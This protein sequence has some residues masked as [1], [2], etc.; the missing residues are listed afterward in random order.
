MKKRAFSLLVTAVLLLAAV[1]FAQEE[2]ASTRVFDTAGLFSADEA[3]TL[4][5][6]IVDF[7]E[8]TGYDFAI[9]V[10]NEDLGTADY[11]QLCDDFFVN[12]A[13]G[14]GMNQTA[15]LCYLD[16]Y[17]DGYYYVSA[18]GD[19]KNLMVTEDIQ[20][21]ANT[22]MEYFVKGDISGGFLWTINMLT[23]ALTN[24]GSMNETIRVYDYAEMLTED[25]VATLESAIADF[26]ALS[27]KDFLYLSTYENLQGNENGDYMSG[28]YQSHGFGDGDNRSGVMIY[29]DLYNNSYYVQ[30][31]GD[32][33]SF[34]SQEALNQIMSDS[35]APMGEGKV[36]D[37]VLQVIGAYS[38]YFQ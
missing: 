23:E 4:S 35:N 30:N 21:L 8:N 25:E 24:I 18:Y 31:F 19:L 10:T 37:A 26:R 5:A 12:H 9:Y 14:L 29:L 22:G 7:Q 20:Y 1:S 27:G 33:D 3:E 6:A 38:A 28:F 15:L 2:P 34:V 36:L 17:G 16:L 13:L 11:Q 32:M